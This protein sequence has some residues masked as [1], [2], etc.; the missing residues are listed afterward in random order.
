MLV[1][2]TYGDYS[3]KILYDI[4][5]PYAD[6]FF[7]G[8][9]DAKAF[10]LGS[11]CSEAL[12]DVDALFVRSTTKV[13][14]D[15]LQKANKLTFVATATAGFNHIDVDYL[16]RQG[17]NWYA[18]GGCNAVAVAE[19]VLSA[20]LQ[21]S[22]EDN[23]NLFDKKVAIIGAGHV[24]TALSDI[25]GALQID[26]VLCD[27]PLQAAG[28]GRT[29]VTFAEALRADII[30]LHTP[31]TTTGQHPTFHMFGKDELLAL[32]AHQYLINACRGEV[33]DNRALLS[34]FDSG[35]HVNVV[36]DVW[37]NEPLINHELIPH[38]RLATAHIAGH[39][40]EGKARGTSMVYDAFCHHLNVQNELKLEQ[41]LPH[42]EN[43]PTVNSSKSSFDQLFQLVKHMYDIKKDDGIFRARMAESEAFA[44]IRK[45]YPIRREF[46]AALVVF[47]AEK[48]NEINKNKAA[49]IAATIGFKIAN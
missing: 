25:L 31:L 49:K 1:L 46:S 21:L 8:F 32:S 17:I 16:E 22:H 12:V 40:L 19:Y 2:F 4:A 7:S 27:P 29:F 43:N 44:A 39:T 24:G 48:A 35:K 47:C 11:L 42:F 15:L 10:E 5:M 14:A 23:F 26:Y 33:V 6:V 3:L 30:C 9:G 41:F 18:A 28:D 34:S 36:L 13:T 20:I 45:H 38:I 37:E